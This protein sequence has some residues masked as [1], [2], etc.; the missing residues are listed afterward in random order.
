MVHPPS[1]WSRFRHDNS[2]W[3]GLPLPLGTGSALHISALEYT[4]TLR[5]L[6]ENPWTIHDF[7]GFA[8]ELYSIEYPS[9]GSPDLAGQVVDLLKSAGLPC[10]LDPAE[11]S[12]PWSM[13]A[14]ATRVSQG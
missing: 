6:R 12:R 14:S 8:P 4:A 13:G 5:Y 9:K 2:L 10:D 1:R 11:G 7:Y 3:I